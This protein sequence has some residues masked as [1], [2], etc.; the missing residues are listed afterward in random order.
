MLLSYFF[1]YPRRMD[2]V[3]TQQ[4]GTAHEILQLLR[5]GAMPIL[6]T[7]PSTLPSNIS[8]TANN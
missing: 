3:R 4:A 6:L 2:S 1:S 5:E 8:Q 7:L